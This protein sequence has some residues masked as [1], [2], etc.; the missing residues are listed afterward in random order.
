MGGNVFL[1]SLI[2]SKTSR[3]FRSI[4][5]TCESRGDKWRGSFRVPRHQTFCSPDLGNRLETDVSRADNDPA[6][7]MSLP[8]SRGHQIY[9]LNQR[10]HEL[11]D[12]ELAARV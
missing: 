12:T 4:P 6:L 7:R 9:R 2:A 1:I 8:P 11:V 3:S 5:S 10:M